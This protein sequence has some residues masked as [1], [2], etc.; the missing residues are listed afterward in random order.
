MNYRTKLFNLH[1][2]ANEGMFTQRWIGFGWDQRY[3]FFDA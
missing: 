2:F 3:K 1:M